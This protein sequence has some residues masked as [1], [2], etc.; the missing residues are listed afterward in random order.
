MEKDTNLSTIEALS[1]L[2]WRTDTSDMIEAVFYFNSVIYPDYK[3]VHKLA[4]NP[5]LG[6]FPLEVVPVLPTSIIHSLTGSTLSHRIYTCPEGTSSSEMSEMWARFYHHRGLSIRAMNDEINRSKSRS[7]NATM[8]AIM[9]LMYTELR[10]THQPIWRAH[11][12]GL[13]ELISL[14][15]GP[16][17][18]LQSMKGVPGLEAIVL[19]FITLG[20]IA[21]TTTPPSE[22]IPIFCR[23]DLLDFISEIYGNGL[24]PTLLCPPALFRNIIGI[25]HVR[26]KASE[27]PLTSAEFQCEAQDLLTQIEDFSPE[28]L[29]ENNESCS[30]LWLLLGRVWQSSVMLYCI[31]SLQALSVL[32][33]TRALRAKRAEHCD[34]LIMCLEVAL[35]RRELKNFMLWP[36]VIAGE[37]AVHGQAG[38]RMLIGTHLKHMGRTLGSPL[39]SHAKGILETFWASGKTGW[40]DCFNKPYA[41]LL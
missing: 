13:N 36:L 33:F 31:S 30:A 10:Q 2:H 27:S 26:L 25:N 16:K 19:I 23:L 5:F 28:E 9:V 35:V 4:K 7:S 21:N 41:F 6:Y 12:N 40:D 34:R 18:W 8:T 11:L 29:A 22:Q 37:E 20:A 32:P 17:N 15:G 3:D 38:L 14:R 1:H 39:P 24:Y